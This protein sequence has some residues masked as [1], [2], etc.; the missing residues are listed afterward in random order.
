MSR[1]K[2]IN[3]IRTFLKVGCESGVRRYVRVSRLIFHSV[4]WEPAD[5]IEHFMRLV[6]AFLP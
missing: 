5:I 6:V 1:H 4:L 3:V 2:D